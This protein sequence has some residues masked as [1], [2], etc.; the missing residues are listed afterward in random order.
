[1]SINNHRR[2]DHLESNLL[3]EQARVRFLEDFSHQMEGKVGKMEKTMESVTRQMKHQKK[4]LSLILSLVRMV[5]EHAKTKSRTGLFVSVFKNAAQNALI[6]GAVQ[7]L[8]KVLWVDSMIDGLVGLLRLTQFI[9]KRSME[10]S[11]FLV[12]LSVS[13][14]LFMLL[15]RKLMNLLSRVQKLLPFIL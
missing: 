14:A 10:R 4:T 11:R 12:K 15:R 6:F 9:S 13:F 5:T 3:A 1:M 7:V 8:M 2:I